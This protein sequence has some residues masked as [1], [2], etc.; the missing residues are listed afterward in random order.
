MAFPKYI[1]SSTP[2]DFITKFGA[3]HYDTTLARYYIN[4]EAFDEVW[5]N[6]FGVWYRSSAYRTIDEARLASKPKVEEFWDE[7]PFQSAPE[8][9]LTKVLNE[10]C[11]L[12][13]NL[14]AEYFAQ[15]HTLNQEG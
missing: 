3:V 2:A 4:A 14:C 9:S 13:L 1:V 5:N 10:C 8:D 7:L 11:E 15:C 6:Y 12:A